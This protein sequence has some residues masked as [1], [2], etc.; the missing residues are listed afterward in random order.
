MTP[1][2]MRL[3]ARLAD[4]RSLS[5]QRYA[6]EH[7]CSRA[8]VWKQIDQIRRAGLPVLAQ[9]GAGYRLPW[10]VSL[11]DASALS[12]ALEPA[13]VTYEIR[14]E[15]DSTNRAL[16]DRFRHRHAILAEVQTAGRGRRGRCWMSPLAGG[17]WLSFGYRFD[18]GLARLG[19]LGLVAGIAAARG[20][21]DAGVSV[22]LKW[23]N[24]L[25]VDDRKLGGL[26]VEGRGP[27][28]GPCE[29]VIGLGVNARL[30]AMGPASDPPWIDIHTAT[31]RMP[32]RSGLA[33]AMILALDRA[34]ARFESDGFAAF[35]NH[36]DDLDALAGRRIEL[37]FSD[38]RRLVGCAGGVS[39]HGELK[40]VADDRTVFASAGEVHV[41]AA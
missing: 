4:G 12:A 5:G 41:R 30:P 28:E 27:G 10:P 22:R 36:W 32:D 25:L 20:L 26:L 17:L 9:A 11:L 1:E 15:V 38:G 34:C 13:G 23:P 33:A 14:A 6:A 40:L 29:V 24:D 2:A 3:L 7:G 18:F 21:I 31:G 19:A 8:A 16:S 39:D 37:Q 35:R